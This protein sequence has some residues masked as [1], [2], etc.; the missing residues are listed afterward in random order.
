M[1]TT[2]NSNE[3]ML[4]RFVS[5]LSCTWNSYND[6]M[7]GAAGSAAEDI[8]VRTI[9]FPSFSLPDEG[10]HHQQQQQQRQS[11]SSSVSSLTGKEDMQSKISNMMSRKVLYEAAEP[12]ES[13]EDQDIYQQQQQQQPGRMMLENIS[14][15]FGQLVDARIRA[16]AQI[17]SNHVQALR[18]SNNNNSNERGALIA[19]YKLQTLLEFASTS[20][21]DD[22]LF[23]SFTTKFKV[24]STSDSDGD[25]DDDDYIVSTTTA[26]STEK[27]EE[28]LLLRA[29]AID[30]NDDD[31]SS[32][33]NDNDN[34]DKAIVT[35][36]LPIEMIVE[37]YSHRFREFGEKLIF[38]TTGKIHGKLSFSQKLFYNVKLHFMFAHV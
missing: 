32:S 28:K 6:S 3:M 19:E 29:A 25:D 17:L 30:D 5:S 34:I 7:E 22:A 12:S 10:E 38:K 31:E 26:T 27:K 14:D 9:S 4:S 21:D 35:T 23:D 33:E 18:N 15:S 16:Y 8:N 24:I 13:E 20:S 36:T 2:I 11:S 1:S 37:I